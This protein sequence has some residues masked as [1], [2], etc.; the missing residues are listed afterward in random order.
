[1]DGK[2]AGVFISTGGPGGGQESTAIATLSTLTHH[3]IHYVPLGYAHA[4]GQLT[5][6]QEVHG[7]EYL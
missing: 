6:L 1:L 7:G 5:N 3:G 4:F 2:S